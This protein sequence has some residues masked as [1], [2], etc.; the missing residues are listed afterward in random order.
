MFLENE[1]GKSCRSP[2]TRITLIS[3]TI[4][5]SEKQKYPRGVN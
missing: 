1:R 3:A 4:D 2:K 5:F